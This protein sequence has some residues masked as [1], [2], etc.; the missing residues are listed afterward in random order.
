MDTVRG[1]WQKLD[2]PRATLLVVLGLYLVFFW[3]RLAD[4]GGDISRFV[5]A[6]D[7]IT[8]VAEAPSNLFVLPESVGYDG[9]YYYRLAIEPFATER[10][11]YG[12]RFDSPAYRQQR[13]LYPLLAYVASLGRPLLVPLAL[14]TVNLVAAGL[15]GWLAGALAQHWRRH[16]LSGLGLA[17]Y[18]GLLLVFDRDLTELTE[19]MF[20]TATLLALAQ[21]RHGLATLGMC[22]A[23]L[24]KETS[25]GLAA[26][27]FPAYA[28]AR[29][30]GSDD[31]PRWH[32]WLAPG[33]LYVAW[34]AWLK[35][36]WDVTSITGKT[37]GNNI[38]TPGASRRLPAFV[39]LLLSNLPH[40]NLIALELL[41]LALFGL[42]VLVAL[43]RSRASLHLKLA[44]L[45]YGALAM[46][47][48][49]YWGGDW[50]FMRA[51][52]EYWIIGG[53]I[54]LAWDRRASGVL[55]LVSI[56]YWAVLAVHVIGY[57]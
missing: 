40:F 30:R 2:S 11:G 44:F 45:G 24:A 31:G 49:H 19:I 57:R 39:Q 34:Q 7:R 23:L 47:I 13:I 53:A 55:A 41:L 9:Q 35:H 56:A 26:A 48:T 3:V 18:P 28:W 29:L 27:A 17:L 1:F 10:L 38:V 8:R 6:G 46:V 43:W 32:F 54:L 5:V 14:V 37:I 51:L 50:A 12:V 52:S 25:L 20:L 4:L 15:L 16:A 42:L 36:T 21:R 33:A 22:L